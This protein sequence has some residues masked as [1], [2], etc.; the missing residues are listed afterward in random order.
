ME[1]ILTDIFGIIILIVPT[2]FLG[3]EIARI[4]CRRGWHQQRSRCRP[5]DHNCEKKDHIVK[6]IL[7]FVIDMMLMSGITNSIF[8]DLP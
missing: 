4:T 8:V 7:L 6:F 1:K 2:Y 5:E 3:R